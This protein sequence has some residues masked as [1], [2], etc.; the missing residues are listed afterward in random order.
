MSKIKSRIHVYGDEKESEWPPRYGE[1]QGGS[2]YWD[3]EE[4]KFKEGYPPDD[5]Q[6]FGEA[7]MVLTD[8]LNE[9]FYHE[10]AQKWVE[11]RSAL[12]QANIDTNC[13]TVD[14]PIRHDQ[15]KK[16]AEYRA[17]RS[18]ERKISYQ[19]GLNAIKTGNSPVCDP[20]WKAKKAKEAD[21]IGKQLGVDL[22]VLPKTT[23]RK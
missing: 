21:E 20:D 15:A 11:T 8:T 1:A 4:K 14:R 19:K 23:E 2:Y 5:I 3:K 17:K 13:I 18:R 6:R 10:K 12:E 22:T 7:P 9:P 16:D